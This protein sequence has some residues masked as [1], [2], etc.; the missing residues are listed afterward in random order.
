VV[1][2]TNRVDFVNVINHVRHYLP[3]RSDLM[4][5]AAEY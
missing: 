5:P 4:V 2:V 1:R 3:S